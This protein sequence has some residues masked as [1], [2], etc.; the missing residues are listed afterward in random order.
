VVHEQRLSGETPRPPD[1]VDRLHRELLHR[2]PALLSG[3]ASLPGV[4]A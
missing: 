1:A 3:L 4:E 2:Q